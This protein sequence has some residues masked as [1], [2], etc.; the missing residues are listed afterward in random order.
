MPLP[1]LTATIWLKYLILA[2]AKFYPLASLEKKKRLVALWK[3]EVK[4]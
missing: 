4:F 2:K 3:K 1:S